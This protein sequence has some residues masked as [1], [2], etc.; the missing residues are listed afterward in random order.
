MLQSRPQPLTTPCGSPRSSPHSGCQADLWGAQAPSAQ[1]RGTHPW[2]GSLLEP[3]ASGSLSPLRCPAALR[4]LP[5]SSPGHMVPSTFCTWA[6]HAHP[7]WPGC[8]PAEGP[9]P[10]AEGVHGDEIQS[11]FQAQCPQ[12]RASFLAQTMRC[13]DHWHPI[14]SGWE[15]C[16]SRVGYQGR[17][18]LGEQVPAGSPGRPVP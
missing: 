6:N 15:I 2:P 9:V 16:W 4:A 12:E 8:W 14:G 13:T 3:H 7:P 11:T 10:A 18:P 1:G 17:S 5:A